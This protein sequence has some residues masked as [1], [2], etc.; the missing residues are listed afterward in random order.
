LPIERV[1]FI[2]GGAFIAALIVISLTQGW[3]GLRMLGSRMIRWRVRW[4]LYAV[5]IGL[6]LAV[7]LLTARLNVAL[8][9]SASSLVQLSSVSTTS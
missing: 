6:P 9:A 3:A 8:G 7:I 1:R 4:Y 2:V 5:A